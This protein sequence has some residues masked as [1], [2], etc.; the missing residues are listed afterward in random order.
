MVNGSVKT[1]YFLST[2]GLFFIRRN[3]MVSPVV[4][5]DFF[6]TQ[7]S[8][9]VMSRVFAFFKIAGFYVVVSHLVNIGLLTKYIFIFAHLQ[10]TMK[11]AGK[12]DPTVLTC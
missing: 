2:H 4:R 1:F 10:T 7:Y 6:D 11:P 3:Y 12:T 8:A 5:M 9:V